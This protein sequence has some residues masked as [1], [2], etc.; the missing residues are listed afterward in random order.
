MVTIGEQLQLSRR[1]GAAIGAQRAT[2]LGT[3]LRTLRDIPRDFH[4]K[5]PEAHLEE[6]APPPSTP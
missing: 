3:W 6:F 1:L 2:L 4:G 5:Q